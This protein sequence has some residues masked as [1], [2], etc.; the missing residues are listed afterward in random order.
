MKK[1]RRKKQSKQKKVSHV[2]PLVRSEHFV[3]I[4]QE[5]LNTLSR[6]ILDYR[7]VET[8]GQLFGH[9]T[10]DH[11]PIVRFVLG[12]GAN[13]GHEAAFFRQD[14]DY[15][16][17]CAAILK[18]QCKLDHI[19]EWHSHHTL[20][21]DTPSGHDASNIS[22]NMEILGFEQFL[23]CIGTVQGEQSAA[24]MFLFTKGQKKYTQIPWHIITL[25]NSY[26]AHIDNFYSELFYP[27][28]SARPHMAALPIKD[29]ST[30]NRQ[31]GSYPYWLKDADNKKI[32]QRIIDFLNAYPSQRCVPTIDKQGRV[33]LSI[34]CNGEEKYDIFFP[35]FFPKT[36]PVI[37][38]VLDDALSSKVWWVFTGDILESFILFYKKF[39]AC[40][41]EIPSF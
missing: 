6:Y 5:E 8:G 27:P 41:Y 18:E 35:V 2:E 9:W 12:P 24:K 34:Y 16:R 33:H 38:N 31:K 3:S 14:I 20:G 11:R 17:A 10:Y 21:L 22:K 30:D 1:K 32:L 36:S 28:K 7:T 4:Y 25:N 39:L 19:G 13:A 37:F 23:L 15:L 29:M 26:R 40:E